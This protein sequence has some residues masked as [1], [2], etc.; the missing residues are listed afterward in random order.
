MKEGSIIWDKPMRYLAHIQNGAW[1]PRIGAFQWFGSFVSI[2][3]VWLVAGVSFALSGSVL[4]YLYMAGTALSWVVYSFLTRSLFARRSG[5]YIVFWQSVAGFLCFIP[6]A[7][8]ELPR[9]E[10]PS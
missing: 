2:A 7:V 10:V 8:F 3:G 6:F 4:G 1:H 5:I 9:W